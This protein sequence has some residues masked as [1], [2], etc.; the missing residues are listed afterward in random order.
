MRTERIAGGRLHVGGHRRR[1][2]RRLRGC[3]QQ[4][5]EDVAQAGGPRGG[6][7]LR[8]RLPNV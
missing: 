2:G 3:L 8:L 6:V 7:R 1:Q 5:V 4:P